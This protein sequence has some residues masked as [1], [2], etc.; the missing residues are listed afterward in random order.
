MAAASQGIIR[1]RLES[2]S[3]RLFYRK[4]FL[5]PAS[6]DIGLS[7]SLPLSLSISLSRCSLPLS[8]N[9]S[10]KQ[11]DALDQSQGASVRLFCSLDF[12]ILT[13]IRFTS[14]RLLRRLFPHL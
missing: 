4:T 14:E 1:R 13:S 5:W 9:F 6:F 7:L 12:Y 10:E 11:A 2:Q 8:A 3:F